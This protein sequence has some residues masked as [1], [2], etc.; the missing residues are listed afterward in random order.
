MKLLYS[1]RTLDDVI[2][3]A[4]LERLADSPYVDANLALTR[5]APADWRGYRRRIDRAMLEEAGWPASQ[6]PRVFICGPTPLVESAASLLVELGHD[7]SRVR[8]ER[9]GPTG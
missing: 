8:T 4:E 7:P 5:D 9:F 1:S 3:R 2:Y 6:A